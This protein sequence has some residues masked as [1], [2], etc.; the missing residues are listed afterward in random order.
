MG[1]GMGM[2]RKKEWVWGWQRAA[3]RSGRKGVDGLWCSASALGWVGIG[4]T[5]CQKLAL[6]VCVCVCER[7]RERG[8][9]KLC[10]TFQGIKFTSH[11]TSDIT[12]DN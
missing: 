9:V 5:G 11:S 2:V 1:M 3:E 6:C 4:G 10:E 7:E 8:R 12:I